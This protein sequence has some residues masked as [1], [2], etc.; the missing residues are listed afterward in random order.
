MK[1][2]IREAL[3]AAFI[4]NANFLK[5][6]NLFRKLLK[7]KYCYSTKLSYKIQFLEANV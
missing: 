6:T 3:F 1:R 7:K 5:E 2:S 4:N